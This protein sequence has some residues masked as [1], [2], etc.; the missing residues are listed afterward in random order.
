V[1]AARQL[2]LFAVAAPVAMPEPRL[3]LVPPLS[4]APSRVSFFLGAHRPH[5]LGLSPHSL[6]VSHNTLKNRKSFPRAVAPW[7][8]DSGAF[9]EISQHGHHRMTAAAYARRVELYQRE[10]GLLAFASQQDWM[11]EPVVLAKTGLSIEE[12]QRRTIDN[13]LELCSIAPSVPWMPV[14]QGWCGGDHLEHVEQYARRGIDLRKCERVGVG[15][16]CRRQGTIRAGLILLDVA[17]TAGI[18]VHAFGLKANGLVESNLARMVSCDSMA[19][20]THERKKH[21][22]LLSQ[23]RAL[24]RAHEL[25]RTGGQ[26]K[27]ACAVDWY[28][29]VIAP[30]LGGASC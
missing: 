1:S 16:I 25:P 9:T 17:L 24:G 6:F 19:W 28:H 30:R 26:N 14:L 7:A 11:C 13:Y 18:R 8:L 23:Y 4:F 22:A 27:L 12:H 3:R 10:I 21:A 15:S 29:S 5:W 2:D 20:S